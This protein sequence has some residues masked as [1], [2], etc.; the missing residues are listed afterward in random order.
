MVSRARALESVGQ[1]FRH[2]LPACLGVDG[3]LV[4]VAVVADL[5]DRAGG[6]HIPPDAR[7]AATL[8]NS[9]VHLERAQGERPEILAFDEIGQTLVVV[10]VITRAVPGSV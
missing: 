7:V 6:H 3:D 1:A 4:A 2:D 10:G 9:R 8:A 5:V